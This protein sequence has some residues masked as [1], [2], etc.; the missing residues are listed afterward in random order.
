MLCRMLRM[1]T[2]TRIYLTDEQRSSLDELRK[3]LA[4]KRRDPGTA[5]EQTFGSAPKI[6]VPSRDDW[7]RKLSWP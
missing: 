1:A 4:S 5:L 6:S 2:R 3:L 7:G